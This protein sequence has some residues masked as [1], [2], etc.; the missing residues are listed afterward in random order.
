MSIIKALL[1]LIIPAI[2]TALIIYFGRTY[3]PDSFHTE[4]SFYAE[5]FAAYSIAMMFV[6]FC[7]VLIR[8]M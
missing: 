5:F 3:W 6:C 2:V 4:V 8:E 7:N 1:V